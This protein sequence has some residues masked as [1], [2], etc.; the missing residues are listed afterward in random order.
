MPES[1]AVLACE[2]SVV[3]F[4]NAISVL[5]IV[6]PFSLVNGLIRSDKLT[7]SIFLIVLPLADI[8]AAIRV[9][10]SAFTI[11]F[12]VCPEAIVSHST[13]INAPALAVSEG[14]TPLAQVLKLFDIIFTRSHL[15]SRPH[16]HFQIGQHFLARFII[17]IEIAKFFQQIFNQGSIVVSGAPH[18]LR[19]VDALKAVITLSFGQKKHKLIRIVLESLKTPLG[20]Q[21]SD[22]GLHSHY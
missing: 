19:S 8:V 3:P 20:N 1:L 7:I 11:V 16:I 21:H 12:V 22:L 13:G 2:V 4:L 9:E 14:T 6:L 5:F 17:V 18:G 10:H 15:V